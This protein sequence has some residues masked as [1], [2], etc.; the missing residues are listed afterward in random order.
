M[1]N[2]EMDEKKKRKRFFYC[3]VDRINEKFMTQKRMDNL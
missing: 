1:S 3:M 2:N